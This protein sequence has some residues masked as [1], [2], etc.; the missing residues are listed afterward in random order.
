[1][2]HISWQEQHSTPRQHKLQEII[3]ECI[4]NQATYTVYLKLVKQQGIKKEYML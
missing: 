2:A 4:V 1:M 3:L